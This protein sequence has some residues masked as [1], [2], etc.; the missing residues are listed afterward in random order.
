MQQGGRSIGKFSAT[1]VQ[2]DS[3]VHLS[4]KDGQRSTDGCTELT[5]LNH[6]SF[7]PSSTSLTSIIFHEKCN[8]KGEH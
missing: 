7:S 6:S 2:A 8:K 5:Q 1:P 3:G 4:K